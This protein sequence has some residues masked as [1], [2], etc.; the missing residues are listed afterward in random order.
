MISPVETIK[1]Y[2]RVD[3]REISFFRYTLEAYDGVAVL[4]TL[5]A[6]TGH[7]ALVVAPG[8]EQ[9]VTDLVNSLRKEMLIEPVSVSAA[10]NRNA[11]D[12]LNR[13]N[14]NGRDDEILL[15]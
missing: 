13:N 3:T 4:T 15:Y 14:A 2:Y 10:M 9:D 5:D 12:K 6:R 11:G 1:Q 8:C 7:V